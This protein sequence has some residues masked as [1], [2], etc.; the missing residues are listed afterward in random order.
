MANEYIWE[1]AIILTALV[2]TTLAFFV[3]LDK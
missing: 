2:W 3:N 1:S